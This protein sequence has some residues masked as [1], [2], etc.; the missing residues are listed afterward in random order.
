MPNSKDKKR[1]SDKVLVHIENVS[2]YHDHVQVAEPDLAEAIDRHPAIASK[3]ETTIGWDFEDFDRNIRTANVLVFMGLDFST[4]GFAERA[5]DLDW[6]QMTSA[7]VDHIMPFDWLPEHVVVTNNSGV[8][9]EKQGEFAFTAVLMLNHSVPFMVTNQRKAQWSTKFGSP[10]RGKT[11]AIIGVGAIGGAVGRLAKRFGMRTLGVRRSGRSH[12]HIDE[13]FPPAELHRALGQA[14]FVLISLPHTRETRCLI[15]R[16]AIEAMPEG[17]GIVNVGRGD[18]L[19]SRALAD[20]LEQGKIAGAVLDAFDEEP[21]P[22]S[23]FLWH[24]PNLI[25]SPHCSSSDVGRYVPA[26]LDLTFKNLERY[27]QGKPLL[28]RIDKNLG[29]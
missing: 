28:N 20:G 23:S 16:P 1:Y 10:V 21:L 19:D 2:T 22:A 26:T 29:Y 7:G 11:L 4:E 15:D 12:P 27:M 8:H 18:T 14:D 24:T 5:P 6:I 17:V 3:I 9:A 13:M 25:I